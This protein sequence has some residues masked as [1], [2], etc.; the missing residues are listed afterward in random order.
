M[1]RVQWLSEALDELA[2]IWLTAD[3][4]LRALITAAAHDLDHQ[5]ESTP[6]LVGESLGE[7]R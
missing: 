5:L 1:F 3:A 2:T 7:G 4:A 6:H